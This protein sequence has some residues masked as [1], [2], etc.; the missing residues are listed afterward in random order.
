MHTDAYPHVQHII[1]VCIH[2]CVCLY[3]H[4]SNV[5][6]LF[7]VYKHVPCFIYMK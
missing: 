2:V 7:Y 3:L 4:M 6:N 5:S 1:Y